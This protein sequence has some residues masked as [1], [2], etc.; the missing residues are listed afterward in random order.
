MNV[1]GVIL[2]GGTGSR[3]KPLTVRRSKPAV[4]LAG[5][6]RLVD[7]PISNCI[8]S[9][10][11]RI[12]LL[13][14]YNSVSLHRHIQSTY[15]FD[16]FSKGFVQ[17]LAAE[18]TPE[19]KE[20]FQGTADAVRQTMY[21][22]ASSG[23]EHV[24][25]LSGDQ[26][27]RLDFQQV[28]A[29][30]V[31]TGA[32]VTICSKPVRRSE[33]A[34]LGILAIDRQQLVTGF[35]EKPA[36]SQLTLE[37]RAPLPG[38]QYLA[39]MGIYIF[40]FSALQQL[41]FGNT[42]ADFG[43]EILPAAIRSHRVYSYIHEGYWRDIGTIGSFWQANL[44]LAAEEP[45]F[46]IYDALSPI[47]TNPRFLPPSRMHRCTVDRCLIAEGTDITDTTV[48][49][50][51]IGLRSIIGAGTTIID[52]V[53][54]GNDYYGSEKDGRQRMAPGIG[55]NCHIE[56]AIID[57]NVRIGDNTRIS[58]AGKAEGDSPLYSVRDGVIVIPK[59]TVIPA[60]TVL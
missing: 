39:S 36:D 1:I 59:G 34:G 31:L 57:K 52:S 17:L 26:L 13:T 29:R 42:F 3:L 23:P 18:Q 53:L 8:N 43:H 37:L 24:A 32:D 48:R 46:S 9:G 44:E 33:A 5:K 21:H 54:M 25:I 28:L 47:Y 60:D 35:V 45:P 16:Q 22:L 2:G 12:Y 14:Q 41:L 7:I 58:P 40:N 38:E 6:Y 49:G 50:A 11:L 27:Y 10:I 56:R 30:H 19:S 15:A 4:P 20:W 55:R 51:V